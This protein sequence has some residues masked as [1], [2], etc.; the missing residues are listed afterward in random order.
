MSMKTYSLKQIVIFRLKM[1]WIRHDLNFD[2]TNYMLIF[3]ESL[4]SWR[5]PTF[6]C[7][8]SPANFPLKGGT[9][10]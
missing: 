6:F 4:H 9:G 3:H 7:P 1:N 2:E 5:L 10:A 8:L